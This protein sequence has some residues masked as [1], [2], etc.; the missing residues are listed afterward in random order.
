MGT[1]QITHFEGEQ[2]RRFT[3]ALL[4]DLRAFERLLQDG[5]IEEGVTRIGAEQEMFLIDRTWHPVPM[6]MK[7]L[8]RL[9][10]SHFTTELGQFQL[11]MNLDPYLFTADCLGR[12]ERQM[13]ELLGLAHRALNEDGATMV[14]VGILPT[15]RKSDLG[16]DS[17]VPVPRYRALNDAMTHMRG[18][19]YDFFIKG[20]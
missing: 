9:Q 11:E 10:N 14:L 5:A 7:A 3:R 4:N 17:M 2:R 16:L 8:E 20:V 13:L 1:Q 19:D 15:L 12:T 6:V 18:G